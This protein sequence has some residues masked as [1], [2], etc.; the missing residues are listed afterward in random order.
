[1][2][3]GYKLGIGQVSSNRAKSLCHITLQ[4]KI[5]FATTASSENAL[6]LLMLSSCTVQAKNN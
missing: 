3:H 2:S 1:M 4:M 6:H 5:P